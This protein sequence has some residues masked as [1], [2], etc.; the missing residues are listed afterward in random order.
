MPVNLEGDYRQMVE[1]AIKNPSPEMYKEQ[2]LQVWY[3][4]LLF[5]QFVFEPET[6]AM[7]TGR[8]T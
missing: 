3:I 1:K 8:E 2:Q 6:E 5:I 7:A 4:Y